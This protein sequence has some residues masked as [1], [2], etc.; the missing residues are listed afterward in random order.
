MPDATLSPAEPPTLE[1][2]S[3]SV[4]FGGIMAVEDVT[5]QVPRGQI[6]GLIGP[7][8]AGK[9]TLFDV[10]S[11]VRRPRHGRVLL[12]GHDVSSADPVERYQLGVRRTFQRVQTF[13]WLTV[14]DNVLAATEGLG[15]RGFLG[16]RV[17]W[18]GWRRRQRERRVP[19]R[20]RRSS[21][22]GSAQC[23]TTSPGP[24]RSA[25][26]GWSSSPEPPW[27]RRSSCCSTSR[28]RG[29]TGGRWRAWASSSRMSGRSTRAACSSSSTMQASSCPIATG[30]WSST[31]ARCLL[32]TGPARSR[33]IR[34]CA[35]LTW[36]TPSDREAAN[37][38]MNRFL[39]LVI[40]GA[41]TGG[42][43]SI[44]ASGLVLTYTTSGIF[45]FAQ[46]AIA[47]SVAYLYY[48]LNS[49]VGIPIVPAAVL[50]VLVFA[51]LL[52]LA[53]DRLLLRRLGEAPVYARIVGTIGLLVALPNLMQWVVVTIGNNI[54]HLGL[55][56]NKASNEGLLTPGLGPTPPNV[57]HVMKDVA[58]TSDQLAVF[59]AA[60]LSAI[61]LWLVLRHTRIGL[62]MRAVV[63][64]RHLA[65]LK[66]VSASKTSA[67]AWV[68]TTMLA[69]LGGILISPLFSLDPN[70]FT[71]V[72]LG[73]L[74]A[75]VLGGLRS[76]PIAFL[77]G[78]LLGVVQDLV[79]G[80]STAYP[81][82]IA[83]LNGLSDAV[84]YVLV[85][86]VGLIVGAT[87]PPVRPGRSART[88]PRATIG[89]GCLSS[90]GAGRGWC[91]WWFC[92]A[93]RCTGSPRSRPPPTPRRSSPRDSRPRSS[94]CPSSW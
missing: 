42:I 55:V 28:P 82:F 14:E 52:G 69:G 79:A 47:F 71:L 10:V 63:D 6:C 66:G 70:T 93:T 25:P 23:G 68:L 64:R 34:Q 32:M 3:V 8:G 76:L 65:G 40:S 74:A 27:R 94:C 73:S 50:S 77:G 85:L 33:T 84:P 4:R 2:A 11:G 20:P 83:N 37:R 19:G 53:L 7:N 29:S 58:L 62:E 39:S 87:A 49:G 45:N 12:E 46:G 43:Y 59:A 35:A 9:T 13:G 15:G 18:R 86:L 44:M 31:W 92:S 26:P 48:Q 1:V 38:R 90:V 80:Y 5:L 17:S 78:L 16:D 81:G 36:V 22:A 21:D 30:W 72:V 56:G 54:L 75:V 67:V 61:V 24:S 41:V 60:L 88:G 57:F 89:S 91:S 51:P